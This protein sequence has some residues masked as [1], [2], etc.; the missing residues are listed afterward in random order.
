MNRF[1][2]FPL[3]NLVLIS[4]TV[5]EPVLSSSFFRDAFTTSL[6]GLVRRAHRPSSSM[7]QRCCSLLAAS[8]S[9]SVS[10]RSVKWCSV[11]CC[12]TMG[13]TFPPSCLVIVNTF[14]TSRSSESGSPTDTGISKILERIPEPFY[15]HTNMI[16]LLNNG[17]L[18]FFYFCN[19]PFFGHN[20]TAD[21]GATRNRIMILN[22][23]VKVYIHI[24][25]FFKH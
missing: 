7:Q 20:E 6:R 2:V 8:G 21:C 15:N 3:H 24:Q 10:Q 4:V 19:L 9:S 12:I 22:T 23:I 25:P 16:T 13:T 5:L 17:C 1:L 11:I 14:V 18:Y